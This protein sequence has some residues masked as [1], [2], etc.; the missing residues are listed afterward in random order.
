MNASG[1]A[2]L[3]GHR[4][5][6]LRSQSKIENPVSKNPGRVVLK[7]RRARP[8]FARHPWVF[9]SSIERVEE[10]PEVGDEVAVVSSEGKFIARGLYNPGSAIRV[11]LYRWDDGPLDDSFWAHRLESAIRLRSEVLRL[12]AVGTAYRVVFS[13]GDGLSGLTVD[14]YDRWLVAQFT[15]LALYHRRERFLRLLVDRTG[16][17][18]IIARTERGIAPREGLQAGEETIVGAVPEGPV[19]I[20]ENGLRFRVELALGSEDGLLPGSAREP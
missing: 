10:N 16:A 12:E 3:D 7:S 13:E 17:E 4:D 6:K 14:R 1:F 15:S 2:I 11:R 19:E 18:G 20:V 8:F 5:L 9:E